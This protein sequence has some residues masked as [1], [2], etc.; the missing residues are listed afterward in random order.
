MLKKHY[1][2]RIIENLGLSIYEV[3]M[4]GD[5]NMDRCRQEGGLSYVDIHKGS[6]A[7]QKI[8]PKQVKTFSVDV[9]YGWSLTI[10]H[11][12]YCCCLHQ[13][14]VQCSGSLDIIRCAQLFTF[15]I[16]AIKKVRPHNMHDNLH[17]RW[18]TVTL[19]HS[20]NG[21]ET[22]KKSKVDRVSQ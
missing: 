4:G 19:N 8:D 11:L 14:A 21:N 22:R 18:V 17:F 10:I 16:F 6:R 3:N 5:Q 13:A 15:Y 20:E 1:K 7:R 2:C 9:I 12:Q